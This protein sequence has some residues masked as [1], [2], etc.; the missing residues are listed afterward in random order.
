MPRYEFLSDFLTLL[1]PVPAKRERVSPSEDVDPNA[2]ADCLNRNARRCQFAAHWSTDEVNSLAQWG[3]SRRDFHV[4]SEGSRIVACAALWD[5][6]AF[7]QTVIRAYS[8]RMRVFLPVLNLVAKATGAVSLP[9]SGSVLSQAFVSP[10]ASP[11]DEPE[12]CIELMERVLDA[13]ATRRIEMV[14]VGF[15]GNDPRLTAVRRRFRCREYH[16]RLYR[17]RW[18]QFEDGVAR[19]DD[20]LIC[21]EVSLL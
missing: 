21:P 3:V 8:G 16:T 7:K 5:Q 18:P 12:V 13:V 14:T 15:C 4:V 19:L 10:L 6:R 1:I 9:P 20:G 2:I 17:V 11:W